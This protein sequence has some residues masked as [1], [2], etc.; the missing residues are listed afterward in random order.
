MSALQKRQEQVAKKKRVGDRVR[1]IVF[2]TLHR[3]FSKHVHFFAAF[4]AETSDMDDKTVA[5]IHTRD[6]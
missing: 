6:E 4:I 2:G 3:I 5:A 1:F